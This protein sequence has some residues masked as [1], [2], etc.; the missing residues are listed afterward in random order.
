MAN[1]SKYYQIKDV[2]PYLKNPQRYT[3]TRPISARS[4]WELKYILKFLDIHPSV[5]TWGSETIIVRYLSPIDNK[6][7]RYFVD[8]NFKIKTKTGDVMEI[9]AEIKPFKECNPPNTNGKKKTKNLLYEVKTYYVNSAKW[10][11]TRRIV[12]EKKKMGHKLEFL[13]ISE[14]DCPWFLN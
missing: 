14:K 5:L 10:E 4:S 13:V 12:E 1:E 3:G 11:T 8:F 7:H 9:W 2:Y 6:M